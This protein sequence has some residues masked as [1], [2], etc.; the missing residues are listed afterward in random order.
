MLRTP[1]LILGSAPTV[2]KVKRFNFAGIRIGLGDMPVRAKKLGPY[3][4]WVCANTYYPLLWIQK[5]LEDIQNSNAITL[6]ASMS[7]CNSKTNPEEMF[8][9]FESASKLPNVL[10]YDQRHFEG[11]NCSPKDLCCTISKNLITGPSIQELL[12]K[13]IGH[14]SLI[15]GQGATV[16][17]HGYALAVL[18]RANPI[19]LAG[20]ELP[21][22]YGDYQA[23]RNFFRRHESIP[24][25][26]LR[27]LRDE[28]FISKNRA[29][30]FGKAGQ[31]KILEDFGSISAAAVALGISTICLSE[32]SPL[33]K[34]A[35][36]KFT[37]IA[38]S[39]DFSY[40]RN[41]EFL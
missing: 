25:K 40:S 7:V 17:L 30:D 21:T 39:P 3:D 18:L 33:N 10:L 13:L 31:H 36:I 5:D 34:I 22:R 32:S 27:V 11:K 16:A 28:V 12:S 20:I 9:S 23:Y 37:R 38:E 15:Y 14:S 19:Y 6:L 8:S 4:Y 29:T 35:G 1:A 24:Q 26:I 2:K 41:L